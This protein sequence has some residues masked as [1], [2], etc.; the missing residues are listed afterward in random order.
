[1]SAR[2]SAVGTAAALPALPLC[3]LLRA[4]GSNRHVYVSD[5]TPL[6]RRLLLVGL[7]FYMLACSARLIRIPG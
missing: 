2:P 3:V 7:E 4:R 5:Y 6:G 1:M